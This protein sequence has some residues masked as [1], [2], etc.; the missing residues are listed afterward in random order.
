MLLPLGSSPE[1]PAAMRL[2]KLSNTVREMKY[3]M[4][5]HELFRREIMPAEADDR[6][7]V[8]ETILE[9]RREVGDGEAG[10]SQH[11]VQSRP[12]AERDLDLRI[13]PETADPLLIGG[14]R[15]H[16]MDPYNQLQTGILR[17]FQHHAEDF[18]DLG[19][20]PERQNIGGGEE[21][22][23]RPPRRGREAHHAFVLGRVENQSLR[24]GVAGKEI[25]PELSSY[26]KGVGSRNYVLAIVDEQAVLERN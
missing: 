5:F 16:W 9:D 13:G 24:S 11:R 1:T 7:L 18:I 22:E 8:P 20:V 2:L 12:L 15:I 25:L 14:D 17:S 26:D 19:F 10:T 6:H 21:D 3:A 23:C 4:L